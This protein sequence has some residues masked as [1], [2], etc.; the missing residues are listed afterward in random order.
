[1]NIT[2]TK[3]DN[4]IDGEILEENGILIEGMGNLP[5]GIPQ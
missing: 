5:E 1:M 3:T 2:I 4:E